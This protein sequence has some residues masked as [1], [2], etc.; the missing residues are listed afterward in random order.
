MSRWVL[1][2]VLSLVSIAVPGRVASGETQAVEAGAFPLCEASAIVRAPWDPDVI[3]VADNEE[4]GST[5]LY[6]FTWTDGRLEGMG[7]LA[8]PGP[9]GERPNDIEALAAVGDA[10]LVV[11]S[12][13][14]NKSCEEKSRRQRLRLF[15][16]RGAEGLDAVVSL[17]G[18]ETWDEARK[19]EAKCRKALFTT[20]RPATPRPSAS[21][22]WRQKTP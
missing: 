7:E 20:P 13:S 18:S 2:I 15:R 14:R 10:L 11:G 12:H 19:S 6:S 1:P 17:D 4:Q 9:N 5:S 3:L 21:R 16:W 8:M 22:S